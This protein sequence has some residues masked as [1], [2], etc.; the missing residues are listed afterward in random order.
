VTALGVEGDAD[1]TGVDNGW[2]GGGCVE[3]VVAGD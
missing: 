1:A 3:A 2:V